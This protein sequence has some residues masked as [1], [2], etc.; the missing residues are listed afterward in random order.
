MDFQSRHFLHAFLWAIKISVD[1]SSRPICIKSLGIFRFWGCLCEFQGK[2]IF[3]QTLPMSQTARN[4]IA[5][6]GNPPKA[7]DCGFSRSI[8]Q[9]LYTKLVCRMI[10]T[11]FVVLVC[12][13][14]TFKVYMS[15]YASVNW[16]VR[17]PI[18]GSSK[19]TSFWQFTT[20][21][22]VN[23]CNLQPNDSNWQTI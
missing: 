8:Q 20:S 19:G 9:P 7:L 5:L 23:N 4:V 21:Y 16:N 2:I 6:D 3:Q 14:V 1:I 12:Q 10:L 11:L 15:E 22:H 17:W 18:L 13:I